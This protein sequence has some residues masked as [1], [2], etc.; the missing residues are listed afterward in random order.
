MRDAAGAGACR[1]LAS[2]T[3]G[4]TATGDGVNLP[5]LIDETEAHQLGVARRA[6]VAGKGVT[7]DLAGDK[8]QQVTRVQVSAH[9]APGD[10]R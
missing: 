9:A 7:V 1:N 8:P 3:A 2:A 6:P 10:R 4:A 5:R